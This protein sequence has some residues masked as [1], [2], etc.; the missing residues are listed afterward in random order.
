[1]KRF[2][3]LTSLILSFALYFSFAQTNPSPFDLSTGNYSLSSWDAT[4]P[5]GT[6]PPNMRFH[7]SNTQDPRLSTEMTAD[8]TSAYNLTSGSRI[9]GL[10][11]NGFSFLNTGT[12]GNLGAAVLALNTTNQTNI[13]VTWTGGFVQIAGTTTREY[14]IV[15]Q[16]KIGDGGIFQNVTDEFGNPIEYAYNEYV[17]HPN[18]T[19]LPPHSQT[20]SVVLPSQV[21]DQPIVYLRWKYYF[22]GTG[23]GNRPTL[24]VGN[25]LVESISSIGGATKLSISEIMPSSPLSNI[26]FSIRVTSVDT[27]NI[28]KK[29]SQNTTVKISL[30]NGNGNLIGTLTKVIPYCSTNVVFDNLQYSSAEQ[31]RIKAE[32]ISGDP[33]APA[34]I[35]IQFSEGPVRISIEDVYPKGHVGAIHPNFTLKALNSNGLINTNYHNYTAVVNFSGP[36]SFTQNVNFVNGIAVV[37]N[38]VFST[39]G[40]YAI[41]ATSPGITQSN[42]ETIE[43]KPL[44]TVSEVFIPKYFKGIGTF[45]SRVPTF[46]LLRVDNLHPNTEYRFISGARQ[47]GYTGNPATDN[48]AGN[49]LHYDYR[50]NSFHYNSVRDISQPGNYS[51]IKTNDGETSK[52]IWLTLVPT[53]NLAFNESQQIYW[54]LVLASEK[55]TVIN[56]YRT[57][58]TSISLDFGNSPNKATGIFDVD[59]WLQPKSF[60][61]LFNDQNA[62]DPISIALVQ[63][64]GAVLQD[65]IN[66]Q[67]TPYPPQG[68]NY[69]NNLD[70]TNG[71]WATIIPNN[72]TN[73]I[74]KIAVY[75]YDGSVARTIYDFDGIWAGINTKGIY[76]GSDIPLEFKTPNIRLINPAEGNTDPICNNG[77][78]E[79]RWFARGVVNIDIE[80]SQDSGATFFNIFENIPA[81]KGYVE[82]R[83]PRSTNADILNRIRILDLEHPINTNPIEYLSSSTN[84]FF[85]YDAPLITFN[86]SSTLACR[87][88]N[89]AIQVIATGS[90]LE[91]QWYKDGKKIDGETNQQ[92]I[93]QNVDFETS[94]VYTCKVSGAS[95][96]NSVTSEPILVYVMTH[97]SISKEPEDY[98]GEFGS[99]ASFTFDAHSNGVPPD[100]IVPIRWYKNN[101]IRLND[102][103]RYSGTGSNYLTIKKITYADTNDTYYAVVG[104][105]CGMDTTKPVRIH[106]L[107]KLTISP[108]DYYVCDGDESLTIPFSIPSDLAQLDIAIDLY[109][110]G[111]RQ[112]TIGNNSVTGI[113]IEFAPITPSVVGTY[114]VVVRLI[115]QDISLRSNSFRIILIDR[116]PFITKDL[117]PALNLKVGDPL[118]L[119][120]EAEGVNLSYQ[121]FKDDSK[122]MGAN[123]SSFSLDEVAIEDAGTYFCKVWNC[124][125]I[126]SNHLTLSVSIFNVSNVNE[127]I[128]GEKT[129]ISVLPNPALER[130]QI[131][132][133]TPYPIESQVVLLDNLGNQIEMIYCG[134]LSSGIN[135]FD[136]QLDTK[137]IA[138][139]VYFVALITNG[140]KTIL[141]VVIL[142]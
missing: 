85:V 8:Y 13:R 17:G 111:Q 99:T 100:Y 66:P 80:V 121:W 93:L 45:G 113:N 6:Y 75:T 69:Y 107:P 130:M 53:T 27:N 42:T 3:F 38:I 114:W 79:I 67:G 129:T 50:T 136:Y 55:G 132:V 133:N 139:G 35:D 20:F 96:C 95:V 105:K 78:Y 74:A 19:T 102:D 10:G 34:E 138:S 32:V 33:L 36:T 122:I 30:V 22:L 63:D 48:G 68:P 61:L 43:I 62:T 123:S 142:N 82:W 37:S 25:I 131:L 15:L 110:D 91:Y 108:E 16:Y 44:P 98:Y 115:N 58:K 83:I 1:M 106:V 39:E 49:N 46:A 120:I 71:A 11:T 119:S 31:I 65:G 64:D 127:I 84:D 21:E 7:R 56:R 104:G 88:E 109:K 124:D 116:P 23:R 117:P 92:L 57:T 54:I 24:R 72:L 12:N 73:G 70:G 14:H 125:T 112:R 103:S 86:S 60:V 41:T 29:V 97:T 77:T 28:S 135:R 126:E 2:F 137:Q 140:I 81:N 51:L 4:N 101:G 134:R 52:L 89:V 40:T 26:P 5:A 9:N 76:G 118:N 141:P 59:S 94:A 128:T 87:N 18:P 47:V 90:Q